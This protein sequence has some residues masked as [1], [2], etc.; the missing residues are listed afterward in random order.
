MQLLRGS[1]SQ[2]AV[3]R[4]RAPDPSAVW[5]TDRFIGTA[6]AVRRD[7]FLACGGYREF[8]VHQGEEGDFCIRMLA[9]GH[10]VRLGNSDPI[11][12]FES[13]RRDFRRMDYYDLAVTRT[14]IN[15]L[16]VSNAL[17]RF[18]VQS[19]Q[20]GDP[21]RGLIQWVPLPPIFHFISRPRE[22]GVSAP[23]LKNVLPLK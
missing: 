9:G 19:T 22:F 13:P 6:H 21:E 23:G 3:V 2:A 11:H 1:R 4:Q 20:R 8:L 16:A 10:H 18:I 7:V 15:T 12:H 17:V 5:V 14:D